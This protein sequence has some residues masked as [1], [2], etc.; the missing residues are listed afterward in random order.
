M[1][2]N[3]LILLYTGLFLCH[4][5][6]AQL[7][8]T[9]SLKKALE[10]TNVDTVAWV[11]GGVFAAG[12][13]LGFLHNWPAGGE[14]VS[15]TLN[16]QFN[17]Y[18]NRIIHHQLWANNLDM[19]YGLF[20]AYSNDFVPRKMDDRI[21]FTSKYGVQAGQS[22]SFYFSGLFNFKSQFTK[23]YDY[24]QTK[25]DSVSTSA[26][27]SP[28]YFT[29]AVGLEYR[30]GSNLSLFFSPVASRFT[31][32]DRFYTS[33]RP[34]GA[35]GI[36]Y[37]ET[38]RFELGAYFSGRVQTEISK[39]LLYKTRVDVYCNY[40]ARDKKDSLGTVVMKDNPGNI[41]LLWD[42]FFSYKFSR[43]WGFTIAATFI[44]DNDIPYKELPQESLPSGQGR[45][46][47][48]GLGWWQLKQVL[49]IGLE[50]RF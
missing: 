35:F 17:G 48:A 31:V 4:S 39:K 6:S 21:D 9:E 44:Y 42:N 18:L 37:N 43:F 47:G 10:T 50:Y 30:R 3:F 1:K 11:R 12:G 28:A 15:S 2:R 20:Y 45:E 36:Q 32:A 33:M 27:L 24:N 7:T 19:T 40:L 5:S 13:N 49:S 26:F 16:G 34:E 46:P 38:S 8:Q 29:G 41:D 23:G 25:W 14:I 22:K